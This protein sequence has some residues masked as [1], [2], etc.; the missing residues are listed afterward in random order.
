MPLMKFSC[1][2]CGDMFA[3]FLSRS[4]A[5]KGVICPSC[6]SRNVERSL[7]VNENTAKNAAP[8]CGISKRS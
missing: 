7:N 2:E 5:R 6:K 4:E 3:L 1:I 8:S